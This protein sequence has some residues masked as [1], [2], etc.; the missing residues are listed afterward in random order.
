MTDRTLGLFEGYGIE[1]EYM[2]VDADTLEVRPIADELLKA[3]AG[4]YV[5]EVE[6][7]AL[8]WSN[9]LA[10][11]L[12]ELKTNGPVPSLEGVEAVFQSG[13][14]EIETVLA[15]MNARL[16]PTGMH[17]W[18]APDELRLW[19][20]EDDVIYHTLHR[21]F[22]CRGHGW[23]NLQSVHVN[24]PFENDEEL[25][26][27]HA[28]IR[29]VL[30][31]LPAL[32]ASSPFVDG[33]AS[34]QLDTRLVVYRNNAERIPSVGGRVIPEPVYSRAEYQELLR[35]IYRDL[36]PHDPDGTLQHEWINARGC[37]ARFDRMTLEIRLLDVQE[38]PRMD[39]AVVR[40]AT[41]AIRALAE[42]TWLDLDELQSFSIDELE[43]TLRATVTSGER[44]IVHDTRFLRAFGLPSSPISAGD[45]WR[46][47]LETQV[48]KTPHLGLAMNDLAT[49]LE[50]GC[51]ARRILVAA[52]RDPSRERL[53]EVYRRLADCLR[54]GEVF[55]GH[56]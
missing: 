20:H 31:I 1:I 37:I 52:G 42:Q 46:Y 34:G 39:L 35:T 33:R 50:Q 28:A 15:P 44:A 9:E 26:L 17:P 5:M 40:A 32:A 10:L 22:D 13:I 54:Y 25:G 48:A 11:H 18:M 53:A 3:V 41:S 16:M 24:L 14:E 2:I 6:R 30:P 7:G 23:S 12:I 49:I 27:L 38:C 51:L 29:L 4:S 36:A 21:I 45:L 56:P 43:P 55:S 47:L 19:P 8:R